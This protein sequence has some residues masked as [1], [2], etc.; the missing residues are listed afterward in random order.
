MNGRVVRW[1]CWMTWFHD[2]QPQSWPG[3]GCGCALWSNTAP[4]GLGVFKLVCSLKVHSWPPFWTVLW[5]LNSFHFVCGACQS[6]RCPVPSSLPIAFC[7]CT[8]TTWTANCFAQTGLRARPFWPLLVTRGR[9]RKGASERCATYGV[10]LRVAA[11][12]GMSKSWKT[13]WFPVQFKKPTRE[14]AR[15]RVRL[16][17]KMQVNQ[18]QLMTRRMKLRRM[19]MQVNQLQQMT[20]RMKLRRMKMQVNQLQQMTRRMKLC[21]LR[22][23]LSRPTMTWRSTTV[24]LKVIALMRQACMPRRSCWGG[25]CFFWRQW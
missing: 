3:T 2:R 7:S 8:D 24:G 25:K 18:L 13:F 4:R 17:M 10:T 16:R 23:R 15:R 5:C 6:L 21:H 20:R 22:L 19:K 14:P 12:T 11:M 1:S 9:K